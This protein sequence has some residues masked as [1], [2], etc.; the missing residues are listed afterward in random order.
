[1]LEKSTLLNALL[2]R[3]R[4]IVYIAGTTR[5]TIEEVFWLLK[6]MSLDS[7][8]TVGLRGNRRCHS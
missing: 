6:E 1:M 2:K 7:I 8:D 3:K 4:A 5:D